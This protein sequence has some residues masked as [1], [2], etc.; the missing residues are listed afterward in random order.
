M[1]TVKLNA[2]ITP[3]RQLVINLPPDTPIGP[4]EIELRVIRPGE[5]HEI[6]IPDVDVSAL[7]RYFDPETLEWRLVA[8]SG[9]V[10]EVLKQP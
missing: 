5:M 2:D 9:V 4:A 8:R 10:R 7:P 6:H 1:F 3:S